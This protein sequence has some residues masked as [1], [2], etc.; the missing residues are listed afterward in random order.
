MKWGNLPILKKLNIYQVL[1]FVC[2]AVVIITSLWS[3]AY[4]G[5]HI[6]FKF[7]QFFLGLM[8]LFSGF[9]ELKANRKTY[10]IISFSVSLFSILVFITTLLSRKG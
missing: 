4:P 1:K 10:A 3:L 7:S 2:A 5:D 9:S 8:F 6:L